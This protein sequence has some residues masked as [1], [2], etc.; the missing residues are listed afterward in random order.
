MQPA[1]WET[2]W[3]V[4]IFASLFPA[5]PSVGASLGARDVPM[6]A[7][8]RDLVACSPPL[9]SLGYRVLLVLFYVM[10]PLVIGRAR[11][12]GSL[13]EPERHRYMER[14][15]ASRLYLFRQAMALIKMLAGVGYLGFPSVA[16]QFG[17]GYA[18]AVAP[19]DE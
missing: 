11:L 13:T 10:P 16:R 8:F 12:F 2:R 5:D 3:A 17:I 1:E 9:T 18:D 7:Y 6:G 15:C 19:I 14:W 4:E